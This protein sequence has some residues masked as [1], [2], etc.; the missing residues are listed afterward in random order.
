MRQKCV[1]IASKMRQ[2]CAEH[3]RGRTP[4][5]RYQFMGKS[6]CA[7]FATA[8]CHSVR[9]SSTN[10]L[11]VTRKAFGSRFMHF[12]DKT[13]DSKGATDDAV[14]ERCSM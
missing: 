5:G 6:L 2:K 13:A 1:K 9:S 3:L 14:L 4:F 8:E 10:A 7:F 12:T 11:E